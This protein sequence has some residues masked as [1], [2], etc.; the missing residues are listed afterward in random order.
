MVTGPGRSSSA[1][2]R[3]ARRSS[4][5]DQTLQLSR[6]DR[7]YLFTGSTHMGE[8]YRDTFCVPSRDH[9]NC[10]CEPRAVIPCRFDID[11]SI[12]RLIFLRQSCREI[13]VERDA[14]RKLCWMEMDWFLGKMRN[15]LGCTCPYTCFRSCD[16]VIT[17]LL[18]YRASGLLSVLLTLHI[19]CYRG[20]LWYCWRGC[21]MGF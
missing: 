9:E 19:L 7:S 1:V 16:A 11:R 3:V 5:R 12:P 4:R 14:P 10:T 6:R 17:E 2:K 21:C 13:F 15:S 20:G 18:V 8:W